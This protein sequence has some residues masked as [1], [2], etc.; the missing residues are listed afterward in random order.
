MTR[1]LLRAAAPGLLLALAACGF[2]GNEE[3]ETAESAQPDMKTIAGTLTYEEHIPLAPESVVTVQLVDVSRADDEATVIAE[4]VFHKAGKPPLP[5]AVKYDANKIE[6]GHRYSMRAQV[7]EQTRLMFI[8]DANYPV[9]ENKNQAPVDI[10]LKH[11]PGGH[12]ERMAEHVRANNPALSGFYRYVDS[13]GEFTDCEDGHSYPL[14]REQGIYSLESQYRDLASG[15]G[16]EVFVSVAGK[17]VTKPARNG[18]GKE[19]FLVVVQV[20]DMDAD[21]DCP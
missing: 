1:N 15:Y 2:S 13:G 11:V 20:E 18:R 17:Y 9:L 16:D 19:K 3:A 21:G 8:S 7:M 12:I 10:E 6:K 4:T 14:A 5:Y